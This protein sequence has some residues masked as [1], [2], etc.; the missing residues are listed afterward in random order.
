MNNLNNKVSRLLPLFLVIFID[1]LGYF[2]VIPVLLHLF[3]RGEYGLIPSS[4]SLA[5]RNLLYGITVTLSPLAFLLTAPFIGNFSDKYGRKK[6]IFWCLVGSLLGF[7][8]PIIGI[9]NGSLTLLLLG[10]FI[11]GV[12]SGSQPVAQAAIADFTTGKQKAFHLAMIAFA[13]TLAMVL[14]PLG[15]GY[16]SDPHLVSWFNA[17]TPY[18]AGVVLSLLN[19]VLLLIFYSE[20]RSEQQK[21]QPATLRESSKIL[22]TIIGK[23]N[24]R[25]LLLLLLLIELAWS[26]YY[27][28][29]FL[30]L[31]EFFHY[32]P[33]Q[34]G[35]FTG[36][37]GFWMSLGLTIIYRI[38][39][40]YVSIAKILRVSVIMI[41]IGFVAC[42]FIPG[43]ISQWLFIILIALFVG[44]SY[45]SL[46]AL[47]S[48][49]ASKE[50]QGWVMGVA[51]TL[52]G[53][54]WMITAF[55]SGWLINYYQ[56][57]P[58]FFATFCIIVASLM[59]LFLKSPK[60]NNA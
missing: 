12:S 20:H 3:L 46:L 40:R 15:G 53:L 34:I 19:I 57:L 48:N 54:A 22:F 32:T 44:M 55:L 23:S 59:L 17:M 18:W 51:S 39:I 11:A 14:G 35:L 42:T 8:L 60:S 56:R 16:L 43:T 7:I 37:I 45:P 13:M 33:A 4:T 36:Y 26:Q 58:L 41:T 6:I 5:T 47:I 50:H 24:V 49:N 27:Q 38:A 31:A 52:L 9:L 29:I 25:L 28:V 21:S 10:R 1:S 30:Y 2:L